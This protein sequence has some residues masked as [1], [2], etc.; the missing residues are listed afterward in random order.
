MPHDLGEFLGQ[1]TLAYQGAAPW[2]QLGTKMDRIPDVPAALE[3]AHLNWNVSL[4]DLFLKDGRKLKTRKAVVRD[5][6]LAILSTVGD[7]Y[8]PLQNSEAFGVLQP[9]CEQF[10]VTIETAGMLK[11]GE[12]VWMLAKLP[13]SVEVVPGD[14]VDGYF[15]VITGHNGKTAF[16]A[17]PTPIRVVCANTIAMA[18]SGTPYL[19][20]LNHYGQAAQEVKQVTKLVTALVQSL[21]ESGQSF[22]KLAMKKLSLDQT[23]EY[24]ADVLK[25]DLEDL[26]D[27]AE[28]NPVLVQR[29]EKIVE[30]SQHGKGVEFA[31]NSAWNALNAIT[32]YVDHVRPTEVRS[33]KS[34]ISANRSAIFGKNAKVKAR[35]LVLAQKMVA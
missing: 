23:K 7:K 11:G 24:I 28:E 2:H 35:A 32:E 12:K 31:P 3:A 33:Q 27:E 30:L 15:L 13:E 25:I 14:S 18:V 16:T 10:G 4:E 22:S 19:V 26:E 34:M 1:V 17:R 20:Q 21:K 6:D 8:Q 5:A 29:F 9:A